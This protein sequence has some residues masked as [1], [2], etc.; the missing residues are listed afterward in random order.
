FKSEADFEAFTKALRKQFWESTLE[1][2]YLG[3]E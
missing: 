1:G 3:S 2:E